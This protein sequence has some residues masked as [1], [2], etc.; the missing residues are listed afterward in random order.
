MET[1]DLLN[2]TAKEMIELMRKEIEEINN[3]KTVV[4]E[5]VYVYNKESKK[6]EKV[7]V[8][9]ND[10]IIKALMD[11][12]K[13][14]LT[15][16]KYKFETSDILSYSDANIYHTIRVGNSYKKIVKHSEKYNKYAEEVSKFFNKNN[17]DG[18]LEFFLKQE[19]LMIIIEFNICNI[20]KDNDNVTK[21]FI[22]CLFYNVGEN[23]NNTKRI[24]S[25][26]KKSYIGKDFIEFQIVRLTDKDWES[27]IFIESSHVVDEFYYES[28]F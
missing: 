24:Y 6:T 20:K 4:Y 17:N 28:I 11:K 12:R 2:K 9:S 15:S 16:N 27:G 14:N 18:M 22:D 23:D 21:P 7:S 25:S 1:I 5:D 3:M 13:T 8:K 26:V 10:L 19:K